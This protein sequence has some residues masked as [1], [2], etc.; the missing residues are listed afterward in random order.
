M[1]VEG[2][3]TATLSFQSGVLQHRAS[4]GEVRRQP[5][6]V[7]GPGIDTRLAIEMAPTGS[8]LD[9]AT[10]F[11]DGAA[12]PGRHAYWLRITQIDGAK[13]WLSPWFVT[14][15]PVMQEADLERLDAAQLADP[16]PPDR[17]RTK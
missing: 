15:V 12:P 14:G 6:T 13:A 1:R 9:V 3:D 11:R 10:T 17:W 16:A 7:S 5:V 2:P 4:L 8:G